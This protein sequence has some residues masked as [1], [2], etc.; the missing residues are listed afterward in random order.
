MN[1]IQFELEYFFYSLLLALK[2][3]P[4]F[5]RLICKLILHREQQ[6][7]SKPQHASKVL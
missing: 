2:L 3:L 4:K 6:T 5:L 7:H 1:L